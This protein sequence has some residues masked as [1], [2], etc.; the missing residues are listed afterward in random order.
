ML[1]WALQFGLDYFNAHYT[2]V[3]DEATWPLLQLFNLWAGR[4]KSPLTTP[5][6]FLLFHDGLDA[7]DTKRFPTG[8]L[9]VF[10]SPHFPSGTTALWSAQY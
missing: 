4:V 1:G 2:F 9:C 6:A 8:E 5:G 3:Q 7:A 10:G